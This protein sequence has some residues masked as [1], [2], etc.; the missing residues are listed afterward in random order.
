MKP[1]SPY[2]TAKEA[3]EYMRFPSVRAFYKF[4]E[5]HP[6]ALR[7]HRRGGT[8][9]FKQADLDAALDVERPAKLRR[10]S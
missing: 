9:L 3:A 8:L 1:A 6:D 4:R 5:R 2:L 10:A 7:T